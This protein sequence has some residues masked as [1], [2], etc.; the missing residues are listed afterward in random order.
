M[1][2]ADL[3]TYAKAHRLRTRNLHDGGPVGPGR[4]R[5]QRGA[6]AVVGGG[7]G[8]APG[9]VCAG[10]PPAGPVCE[11]KLSLPPSL[12]PSRGIRSAYTGDGDRM[13]WC[14]LLDL[15]GAFSRARSPGLANLRPT[16]A[17]FRG[18]E[19]TQRRGAVGRYGANPNSPFGGAY[20]GGA[21]DLV[22][23]GKQ[24]RFCAGIGRRAGGGTGGTRGGM[25]WAP[26]GAGVAL[27]KTSPL[28]LPRLERNLESRKEN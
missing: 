23:T 12:S 19:S 27:C 7:V 6:A 26:P 1:N 10:L 3:I 16:G 15:I 14:L 20:N 28:P 8:P 13:G 17:A 11:Y 24:D 18:L 5:R 9:E 22:G 25:S 2:R 21:G 4:L